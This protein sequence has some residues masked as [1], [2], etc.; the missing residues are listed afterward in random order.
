MTYSF[1][2]QSRFHRKSSKRQSSCLTFTHKLMLGQKQEKLHIG[3]RLFMYQILTHS[4]T[5]S[6]ISRIVVDIC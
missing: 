1:N 4:Y 2:S 3:T 5:A 6:I